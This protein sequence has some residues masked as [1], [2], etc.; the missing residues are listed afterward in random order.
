MLSLHFCD[1]F[2][3]PVVPN[4]FDIGLGTTNCTS[5]KFPCQ[6]SLG[7]VRNLSFAAPQHTSD[8]AGYSNPMTSALDD[9]IG[10]DPA[11]RSVS[12]GFSRTVRS[13]VP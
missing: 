9:G 8:P 13:I 11:M 7:K 10:S 3:S 5:F 6:A 4:F 2:P 12:L 1:G